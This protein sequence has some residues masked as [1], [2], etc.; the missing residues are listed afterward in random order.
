MDAGR[1][2]QRRDEPGACLR[3][4]QELVLPERVVEDIRGE[5]ALHVVEHVADVWRVVDPDHCL[6]EIGER[7]RVNEIAFDLVPPPAQPLQSDTRN[8][9]IGNVRVRVSIE[10][11]ETGKPVRHARKLQCFE[12][13]TRPDPRAT[14]LRLET[15][16]LPHQ[17][18]GQQG[19]C[20]VF[21]RHRPGTQDID[22]RVALDIENPPHAHRLHDVRVAEHAERVDQPAAFLV[23]GNHLRFVEN[24]TK[25]A[26][27]YGVDDDF[28]VRRDDQLGAVAGG[29]G[30]KLMIDGV[31][32]D[33]VQMRV[34]FVQQ[35]HRASSRVEKCEQHQH[36]LKSASRACDVQGRTVVGCGVF[37]SNVCTAGIRWQQCVAE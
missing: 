5:F 22:V 32:Q 33:H 25:L 23:V 14:L 20:A 16:R 30:S 37:G 36:L 35:Q 15:D 7:V 1:F 13:F 18:V 2:E 17:L 4:V 24:D 12:V 21:Q 28:G 3:H 27:L 19:C 10:Q 9:G 31:L 11:L 34:R 8:V 26:R 6:D 29:G